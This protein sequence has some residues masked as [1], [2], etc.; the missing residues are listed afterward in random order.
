[1]R[2]HLLDQ[3]IP[4]ALAARPPERARPPTGPPG[5]RRAYDPGQVRRRLGFLAHHLTHHATVAPGV[6]A[7]HLAWWRLAADI[8]AITWRV[9]LMPAVV[10]ALLITLPLAGVLAP[11]LG[12]PDV[13]RA[14]DVPPE[15]QSFDWY[16]VVVTS[17][18]AQWLTVV[19]VGWV[20][21]RRWPRHEPGYAELR[22]SR[23]TPGGLRSLIVQSA[24]LLGGTFVG[25]GLF[26]GLTSGPQ[27]A[28]LPGQVAAGLAG[29]TT[30]VLAVGIPG[31][32]VIVVPVWLA[33]PSGP[34][35]AVTPGRSWRANRTLNL[36]Y[37]ALGAGASLSM[38]LVSVWSSSISV[39]VYVPTALLVFAVPLMVGGHHAWL[40]YRIAARRLARYGYLP[41]GLMSF[42]DDM[43]RL[44]LL[45]T[46]GAVYQFRHDTL[47]Q[48]LTAGYAQEVQHSPAG[49]AVCCTVHRSDAE[50]SRTVPGAAT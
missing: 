28:G 27:V 26:A 16:V 45:R 46:V 40:A 13:A 3:L 22:P 36:T 11:L 35:T 15:I 21:L 41:A 17:F 25:F 29:G 4:A 49:T 42:L 9:R 24:G 18:A 6:G 43:H 20:A 31:V 19:G 10:G 32:L 8:G 30:A 47:R 33:T 12:L 5:P 7:A 39:V 48:H 44:G 50:V 2:T 37:L 23:K 38:T 1:M 14:L 34:H